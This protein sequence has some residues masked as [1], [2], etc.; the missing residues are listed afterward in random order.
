MSS[1]RMNPSAVWSKASNTAANCALSSFCSVQQ[2]ISIL[3][4]SVLIYCSSTYVVHL[5]KY[6]RWDL[7]P[8]SRCN[9]VHVGVTITTLAWVQTTNTIVDIDDGAPLEIVSTLCSSNSRKLTHQVF[10]TAS[11]TKSIS[12]N[13]DES[14]SSPSMKGESLKLWVMNNPI[15]VTIKN[16]K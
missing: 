15:L 8:K 12:T 9:S 6:E 14:E 16:R 13:S 3:F 1:S 4:K 2:K 11:A 5:N 10:V 7:P